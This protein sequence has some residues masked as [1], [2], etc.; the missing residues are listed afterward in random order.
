[1]GEEADIVK[2]SAE[3]IRDILREVPA[4]QDALQPAAQ[5]FGAELVPIGEKVAQ[6][7]STVADAVN[8]AL[9]P[10]KALV[11]SAKQINGPRKS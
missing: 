3:A 9:L 7:L 10:L 8:V 2:S 11:W 6:S 1:M 5:K 4:Y